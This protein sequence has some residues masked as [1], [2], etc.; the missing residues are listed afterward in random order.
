MTARKLPSPL[1]CEAQ[2]SGRG[3]D[4][5]SFLRVPTIAG[6]VGHESPD[7]RRDRRSDAAFA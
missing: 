3:F 2:C 1:A 5:I 7:D 4:R 6:G